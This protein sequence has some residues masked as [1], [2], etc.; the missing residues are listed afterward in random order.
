MTCDAATLRSVR[1][2]VFI[3]LLAILPIQ[4]SWAVASSYCQHEAGSASEHFGHH[5][6]KHRAAADD[7]SK[8]QK[9]GVLAGADDDCDFCHLGGAQTMADLPSSIVFSDGGS[10]LFAYGWPY[11]S[12]IASGPERPE[13]P[14]PLPAVRFGGV[15]VIGSLLYA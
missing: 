7:A 13:R 1:R 2:L 8:D 3:L 14:A 12:Q 6:H 10:T 11:E 5:Q 9:A 4:F 15:V